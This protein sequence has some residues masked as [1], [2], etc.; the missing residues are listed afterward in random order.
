MTRGMRALTAVTIFMGVLIVVGTGTLIAVIVHRSV[1]P[2]AVS[3]PVRPLALHLDEPTGSRIA[4]IAGAGDRL[5]V[6]VQGGG[7]GDRV[8]LVD[9]HSG[10][11]TG[12]ITLGR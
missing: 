1:S 2:S 12:R 11:V 8:V 3:T 7:S 4:A 10:V 5:A 9:P 6:E